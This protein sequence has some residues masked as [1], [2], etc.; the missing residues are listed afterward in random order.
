[1]SATRRGDAH[2][3]IIAR[4][5]DAPAAAHT[6]RRQ[7]LEHLRAN[8]HA[9]IEQLAAATGLAAVTVRHHL[10]ILRRGDLVAVSSV[11]VGR[12]RPRHVYR[13]SPEGARCLVPNGFEGLASQLLD[14]LKSAGREP[15]EAFFRRMAERVAERHPETADASTPGGRLA[16]LALLLTEE[17]FV[18]RWERDGDD[19]VVHETACPYQQ[20]GEAHR[21]V[22]CMDEHL[23]GL[24]T[25]GTVVRESWR[26]DGAEGCAYR[27]VGLGAAPDGDAR[28]AD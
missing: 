12:G 1:M 27:I 11:P 2:G 6:S 4:M 15:A 18:V 24:V 9:T 25:G 17:G 16:T 26:L 5:I 13:L 10:G 7:I 19:I 3:A 23:I 21:E 8:G 28:Q 20:F 22:C 14:A